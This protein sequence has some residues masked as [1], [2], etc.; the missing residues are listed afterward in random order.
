MSQIYADVARF[1][2]T[3]SSEQP[4]KFCWC[5]SR[6][7]LATSFTNIAMVLVGPL[8]VTEV[9]RRYI[10]NIVSY[11]SRYPDAKPL[12]TTTSK[13]VAEALVEYFS[14]ESGF[15]SQLMDYFYDPSGAVPSRLRPTWSG[16]AGR[17]S[18]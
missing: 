18:V 1:V 17:Y 4:G 2:G 7:S 13:D 16:G 3:E 8:P 14:M 10:L 6:L 15:S 11:S 9:G 12:R 5:H